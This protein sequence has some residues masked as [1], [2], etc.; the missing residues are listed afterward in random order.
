MGFAL[1][2]LINVLCPCSKRLLYM[3]ILLVQKPNRSSPLSHLFRPLR[4]SYL[5]RI[6]PYNPEIVPQGSCTAWAMLQYAYYGT[7][8]SYLTINSSYKESIF[9]QRFACQ[10]LTMVV[11]HNGKIEYQLHQPLTD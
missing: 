3:L 10:P 7:A 1:V 2:L 4:C 9:L 6:L 11:V 8:L 5:N